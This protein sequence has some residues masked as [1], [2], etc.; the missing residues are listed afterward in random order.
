[1]IKTQNKQGEG[2]ISPMLT[3]STVVCESGFAVSNEGLT[4]ENWGW[5]E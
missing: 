2:Y 4:E 1:M 3:V 5:D